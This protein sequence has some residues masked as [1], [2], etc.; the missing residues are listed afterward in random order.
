MD[1]AR[2]APS[3][4][5]LPF[6]EGGARRSRSTGSTAPPGLDP[7]RRR[8]LRRAGREL[9]TAIATALAA[10]AALPGY[11][12]ASTEPPA[13]GEG[14]GPRTR[15]ASAEATPTGAI[16]R[17]P[18]AD[19]L[20]R[21]AAEA[22]EAVVLIDVETGSGSRQGSGFIVEPDGRIFT[23]QHVVDDA[24][25]IRVRLASGDVY[26]RVK[27]LATDE[28]RDIAVLEVPGFDLPTLPLGNSDSVGVGT[29]VVAIGSPLGLE[30]TV[31]TGIVSGRRSEPS[32]Y[33]LLQVSAPASR[34]SSGG[35]VVTASGE[36]I[37]IA[38]SQ[39]ESGQNLNFAVPINYARG[40][41][42]HVDGEPVAVITPDAS[43]DGPSSSSMA[44]GSSRSGRRLEYDLRGFHGYRV[45][46]E[47]RVGEDRHRRA[48]ITY[49]RIEAVGGRPRIERWA[50]VE[51][52]ER[53]GPFDTPQAVRR[54]RT[55][56]V[57]GADDLRP[58]SVR[59]EVGWWDGDDWHRKEYSFQ[60][61]R[62]SVTGTIADS[63]GHVREVG[64]EV[65]PGTVLRS[66]RHLAFATLAEDSLVG[67]SVELTTFD[68]ASA[69]LQTDRYDVRDTTTIRVDG[70]EHRVLRVNLA[71]GLK[72][73]TAHFRRS[74][75]RV[76]LRIVEGYGS[77]VEEVVDLET[78]GPGRGAPAGE[79]ETRESGD[80]TDGR[81]DFLPARSGPGRN[82]RIRV[83]DA[84]SAGGRY[85]V[86]CRYD[87]ALDRTLQ[88]GTPVAPLRRA[89]A[90][91][92]GRWQID[93]EPRRR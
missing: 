59:G 13:G 14:P 19:T 56:T 55:R 92:I 36:V 10:A 11:G 39:M 67:R 89:E 25:A 82:A 88:R 86:K 20:E 65:P 35:P 48:R 79:P 91:A 68:A 85:R 93:V 34:G 33:E 53:T 32:G 74:R 90:P 50:E 77:A 81:K 16:P 49:R 80:G 31:S 26:E 17:S 42:S 43:T 78:F 8:T 6:V 37:G 18:P 12:S 75:P 57:V 72:N 23:N 63:A 60:F 7:R 84:R 52:T 40:L 66:A 44:S 41:L 1:R 83:A 51:V 3:D 24:R 58:V 21:L 69:E 87:N 70:E 73:A 47:G 54:E 27:I 29:S 5:R 9:L 46:R 71:S 62:G 30:N 2:T 28:R 4:L 76:L 61:E 15:G 45:E 38:S 22:T 64:R